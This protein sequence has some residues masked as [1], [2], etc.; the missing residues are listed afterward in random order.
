M[1]RI[2]V[3]FFDETEGLDETISCILNEKLK[4]MKARNI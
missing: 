2:D 4:Y 1:Q 3:K